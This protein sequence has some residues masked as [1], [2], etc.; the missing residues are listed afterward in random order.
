MAMQDLL[1]RL[2]PYV[3][4]VCEST[5]PGNGADAAQDALIIVFTCLKQ[6]K[7][8]AALFGWARSI[9]V[10]EAVRS[11]QQSKRT[12]PSEL[13]VRSGYEDFDSDL[14]VRDVLAGL[15]PEHREVIVLRDVQ[16]L[17]ERTVARMLGISA[18]TVKSRLHR[19]R[20]RFRD[21]WG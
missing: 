11:A 20:R 7:E 5:A 16:D 1:D 6:L 10:R 12:I 21:A 14:D 19:A 13:D 8:P 15:S 4:R 2:G 9:A 17:D 3:L 18:G